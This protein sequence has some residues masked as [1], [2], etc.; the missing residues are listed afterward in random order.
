[1]K[2]KEIPEAIETFYRA[3]DYDSMLGA[4]E[5]TQSSWQS[6]EY[7]NRLKVW[8]EHCPPEILKKHYLAQIICMRRFFSLE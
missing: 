2:N 7:R 4:L 5:T 6:N 1:M 3:G 8:L